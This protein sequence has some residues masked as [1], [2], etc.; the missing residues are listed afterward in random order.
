M[1]ALLSLLAAVVQAGG[2]VVQQR[3]AAQAPPELNLSPRLLLWLVR[4]PWWLLGVALAFGSNGAFAAATGAGNVALAE[5]LFTTRLVFALALNVIWDRRRVP[6]RDLVGVGAVAAGVVLFVLVLEPSPGEPLHVPGLTWVITATCT[7]GVTLGLAAV[8]RF[9]GPARKA[10][11]LASG[12]ACLFALQA[13]LTPVAVS[14]LTQHGVLALLVTWSGWSVAASALA[15][16]LLLQSAYEAAPL[17]AS[18]PPLVSVELLAGVALGIGALGGTVNATPTALALGAVGLV[19][20]VVGIRLLATSPLVTGHLSELQRQQE[21]GEA[22]RTAARL[23][24]ELQRLDR[25]TARMRRE[26]DGDIDRLQRL[27]DDIRRR[28][29]EAGERHQ[30]RD[31]E[32]DERERWQ[33][34]ERR[35]REMED[36]LDARWEQLR[37]RVGVLAH[38]PPEDG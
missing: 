20:I 29:V 32:R 22:A 8:G 30:D 12:A 35:L 24:R 16:M 3:T 2:S 27:Y 17:P 5:A 23:E 7:V 10:T 15:G 34:E 38:D 25:R 36:V 28:R 21:I 33:D 13:V 31:T 14:V 11:L 1:V 6:P 9:L 37:E 18:Y 4:R 19:V 26:I